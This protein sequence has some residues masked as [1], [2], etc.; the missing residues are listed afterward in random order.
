VYFT[1]GLFGESHGLF[2]SLTTVAPGSPEGPAEA[3]WVQALV[4]LVQLDQA[5]LGHDS[6][7]G[8]SKATIKQD[9]KILRADTHQLNLAKRAFA[10]DTTDDLGP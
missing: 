1:A 2:G 5:V 7:S 10:D 4:D 9:T 8:A 3:Q 6:S